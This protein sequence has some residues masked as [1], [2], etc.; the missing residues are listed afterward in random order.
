MLAEVAFQPIP[1]NGAFLCPLSVR[2]E[3]PVKEQQQVRQAGLSL[4]GSEI[5]PVKPKS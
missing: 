4:G 1:K 3:G 5:R 2:L